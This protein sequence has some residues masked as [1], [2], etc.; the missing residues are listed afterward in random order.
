MSKNNIIS[1]VQGI[2]QGDDSQITYG[3]YQ[4]NNT[5][6]NITGLAPRNQ[7]IDTYEADEQVFCQPADK[8]LAEEL[9]N[10]WN[11]ALQTGSAKQVASLYAE[12][13]VLLPTVS[14]VPRTST[15][16]IEDYFEH[17]L[18]KK[19]YGI[20]KQ[21]NIKKGCN[22]L[23]DAGIYDFEVIVDGQKSVIPARYTFVYEYRNNV[24][25]I[26]HHHSSMMPEK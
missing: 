25:K 6:K 20:I 17:F 21:S 12:D 9:F 4:R 3:H 19:P 22:K 26:V 15:K 24:W 14:N 1:G 23:T 10:K 16:E 18:K 7:P 5:Q 2:D 11:Q 8:K 13:A